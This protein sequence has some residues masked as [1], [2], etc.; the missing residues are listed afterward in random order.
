MLGQNTSDVSVR[1]LGHPNVSDKDRRYT[2]IVCSTCV[3]DTTKTPRG[4]PREG[5]MGLYSPVAVRLPKGA[6]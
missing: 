5:L 1:A 3:L 2:W 6:K 4:V